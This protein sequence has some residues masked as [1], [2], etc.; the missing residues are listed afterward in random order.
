MRKPSSPCQK[1]GALCERHGLGCRKGCPEWKE[2]TAQL[3]QY[4]ATL[5]DS[6]RVDLDL[7]WKI[8]GFRR[9]RRK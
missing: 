4:N 7:A 1:G 2:Y 5:N 9:S 6:R 8:D 3:E